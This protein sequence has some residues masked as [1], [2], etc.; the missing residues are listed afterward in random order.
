MTTG[1]IHSFNTRRGTGTVRTATGAAFP[2]SSRARLS[3]GEA[4]S[5]TL[6]GGLAGV[7]ALGVEPV[8]ARAARPRA[9]APAFSFSRPLVGALAAG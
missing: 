8:A 5:F 3:A 2:F 1:I 7:Y 4:V 9:A 6:V